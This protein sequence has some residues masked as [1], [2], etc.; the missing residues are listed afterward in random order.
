MIK[1]KNKWNILN[2]KK[3]IES[4]FIKIK[5]SFNYHR[6]LLAYQN[7]NCKYFY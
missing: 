7:Y 1:V 3:S 4:I 2:Y 5:D 6:Y